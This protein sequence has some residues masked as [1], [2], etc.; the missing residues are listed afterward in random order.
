MIFVISINFIYT[1]HIS[2]GI[3]QE[4]EIT[5]ISKTQKLI[6]KMCDLTIKKEKNAVLAR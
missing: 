3:T 4:N 5:F 1:L 6:H 2:P